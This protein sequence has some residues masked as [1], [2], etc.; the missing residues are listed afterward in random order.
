MDLLKT[1]RNTISCINSAIN[2]SKINDISQEEWLD[3]Y[4]FSKKHNVDNIVGYAVHNIEKI[5]ESIRKMFEHSLD[6]AIMIDVQQRFEFENFF[7]LLNTNNIA[8]APLKGYIM[9]QLYL[10]PDMRTMSDLD[11][12]IQYK[13]TDAC[14]EVLKSNGYTMVSSNVEED[15]FLKNNIMIEVHRILVG[16][17]YKVMYQYY[18]NSWRFVMKE[19]DCYYRMINEDMYIYHIAHL[20]KHYMHG[21]IGIRF[22]LD[23][24]IMTTNYR[25]MDWKYI[26]GELEKLKLTEFHNNV[27]KL[28]EKWFKN[29][30]S[31][32]KKIEDMECYIFN[33]GVHGNAENEIIT[34]YAKYKGIKRFIH[35]ITVLFPSLKIMSATYPNLEKKPWL[36]PAYWVV[37]GINK[38]R[39]LSAAIEVLKKKEPK[40]DYQFN[41]T[42][43]HL[44]EM[45]LK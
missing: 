17:E 30:E 28:T 25:D 35:Y 29:K 42:M 1:G 19:H 38:L 4:T 24:H 32:D 21:G 13:D 34:Q 22:F 41:E 31:N 43:R 10:Y 26:S 8:F 15:S 33:S 16:E 44:H 2:E 11:I 27:I 6:I 45:G 7:S 40:D 39:N 18:K 5:P 14:R 23:V 36:I 20:A 9:K 3:I 12:L 37:R